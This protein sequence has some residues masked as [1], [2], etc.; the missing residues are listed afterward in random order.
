MFREFRKRKK[1][2]VEKA[3]SAC[4]QQTENDKLLLVCRKRKW[5]TEV[6]FPWLANDKQ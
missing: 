1:E 2:L 6:C 4:L 5:K 3:T